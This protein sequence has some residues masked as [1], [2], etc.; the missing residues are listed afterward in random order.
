MRTY[1]SSRLCTIEVAFKLNGDK[2]ILLP[3][4]GAHALCGDNIMWDMLKAECIECFK[5]VPSELLAGIDS[6]K[7][8]F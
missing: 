2:A 4:E 1:Q 5:E 6:D 8:G 3:V 7:F